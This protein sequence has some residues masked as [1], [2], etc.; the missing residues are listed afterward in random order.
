M[1]SIAPENL[2][3]VDVSKLNSVFLMSLLEESQGE[4]YNDEKLESF[5]RSLEAE[6]NP[7]TIEDQD[8]VIDLRVLICN[9]VQVM[10]EFA[11]DDTELEGASSSSSLLS[12]D[13][14]SLYMDFHG[15]DQ[16]DCFVEFGG[17]TDHSQLYD[18]VSTLENNGCYNF[19][20]PETHNTV[21]C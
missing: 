13:D 17:V 4:E 14:L 21:I 5:I 2:D 12:E 9:D 11:L 1:A 8:S 18:G 3:G 10:D 7:T 16:M 20:W 19:V 6:I 15:D